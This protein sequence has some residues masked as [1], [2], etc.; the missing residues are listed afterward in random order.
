MGLAGADAADQH[1]VALLFDEAAAG[2]VV[3]ECLI[4]RSAVKI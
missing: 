2:E 3:D 1:N 4:D